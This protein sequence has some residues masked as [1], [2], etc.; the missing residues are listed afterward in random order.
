MTTPQSNKL[1]AS[2]RQFI[3]AN[4]QQPVEL[5]LRV[6]AADDETQSRLEDAG[7]TIRH[8]L[9]LV[10]QFAVTG[11]GQ[12]ILALEKE[13]WLLGIEGDRSVHTWQ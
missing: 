10:P 4:P 3:Q 8:R 6:R 5:I 7:L 13:E 1:P 9:T 11:P 12:A 2:L